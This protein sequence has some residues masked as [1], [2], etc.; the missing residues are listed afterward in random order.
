MGSATP[1]RIDLYDKT[2]DSI[3]TFDPETQISLEKKN[4]IEILPGREFPLSKSAINHFKNQWHLH[5]PGKADDSLIYRDISKGL[6]PAG[7]EYY[8]SLFFEE[9]ASIFDH[10]PEGA[11]IF[12]ENIGEPAKV[13]WGKA[14]Q[15]FESLR[16]D[17]S[18]PILPVSEILVNPNDFL[19]HLE[20]NSCSFME[21]IK[22]LESIIKRI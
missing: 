8:L 11:R 6:V 7:L 17:T 3:R 15:R 19:D 9:T 20:L 1:F 2:V 10:L 4:K 12:S 5:F 18:K 13:F 22:K 21:E 14:Q 16:Y